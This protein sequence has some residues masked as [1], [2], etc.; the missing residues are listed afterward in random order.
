MRPLPQRR[1]LERRADSIG[2]ESELHRGIDRGTHHADASGDDCRGLSARSGSAR[3]RRRRCTPDH[4]TLRSSVHGFR[5]RRRTPRPALRVVP[6]ER[7]LQGHAAQLR[8]LPHRRVDLQRDP[9]NDHA[10]PEHQQLRRLP[11]HDIVPAGHSLRSC[12]GDGHLR[13]L[14][15]RHDC[16]G[17]RTHTPGHQHRLRGLPHGHEL[18][19]AQDRRSHADPAGGIRLLHH[20]PQRRDGHGQEQGTR[21]DGTGV[22]R[23]PHHHQL[24][25]RRF[26]S[27]RH[28]QQLLQLPQRHQSRG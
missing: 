5:A 28:H 20:L 13:E 14:P 7:D 18:E 25:R 27:H 1:F 22:R 10:Y 9:Q 21:G 17:R 26:R 15:Q 19:S 2:H 3:L 16:S 23:L 12:R 4:G 24:A 11:R 6:R 8:R